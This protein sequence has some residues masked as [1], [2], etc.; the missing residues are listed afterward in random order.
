MHGQLAAGEYSR[1]FA[2]EAGLFSWELRIR[3][4]GIAVQ[5]QVGDD[6]L[7]IV[8]VV[9]A[10][11]GD[12]HRGLF[13]S[14]SRRCCS[15]RFGVHLLDQF[16]DVKGE[17]RQLEVE[18][19]SEFLAIGWIELKRRLL[20]IED[21][22]R[23]P[24][25]QPHDL[26]KIVFTV[27]RDLDDLQDPGL[28]VHGYA[29]GSLCGFNELFD[30][31]G[32]PFRLHIA[33]SEHRD[34]Q[35]GLG[36]LLNDL[37]G[38]DVAAGQFYVAPDLRL[39]A[40]PHAEHRRQRGVKAAD[41]ALLIGRQRLVVNVRVADENLLLEGHRRVSTEGTW[42]VSHTASPTHPNRELELPCIVRR[43]NL[44]KLRIL[45]D[46]VEAVSADGI[47]VVGMIKQI[48]RLSAKR[49]RISLTPFKHLLYSHVIVY[50]SGP[51]ELVARRCSETGRSDVSA[52]DSNRG[53][54]GIIRLRSRQTCA[55][56][57]RQR[58]GSRIPDVAVRVARRGDRTVDIHALREFAGDGTAENREWLATLGDENTAEHP[59]V[60]PGGRPLYRDFPR[61]FQYE[62]ARLVQVREAEVV[63]QAV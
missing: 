58:D 28:V 37:V 19:L 51:G 15:R 56:C 4:S 47:V 25:G 7:A 17:L 41:P 33:R 30:F 57:P 16:G 53:L 20:L 44:S 43:L 49:E 27:D 2:N 5:A 55:H 11:V 34:E 3:Q 29:A 42:V 18:L 61:V 52:T 21:I 14:R 50:V 10:A 23:I 48:V 35:R 12:K 8:A 59:A 39:A 60:Q 22:E 38:K 31:A 24:E 1:E 13:S 26:G 54:D 6:R 45:C 46:A 9:H 62:S 63:C 40:E 32:A 36:K